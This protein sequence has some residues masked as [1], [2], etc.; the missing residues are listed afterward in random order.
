MNG[1]KRSI[2][3]VTLLIFCFIYLVVRGIQAAYE[4]TISGRARN[5]LADWS[6]KVNN[7][8][9]TSASTEGIP[10][11]YTVTDLTNVRSGKVAPGTS[12]SYPIQ[13]D[14]S[15]SEV[16]IKFTMD[17]I[18]STVDPDKAMTLMSITN[19]ATSIPLTRT[20]PK[21]YTGVIT[22]A[23]LDNNTDYSY[24]MAFEFIDEEI[25]LTESLLETDSEDLFV[26]DFSAIQYMGETIT[27]YTGG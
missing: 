5:D 4:S 18:D 8:E 12:L 2:L 19:G 17:I 11:T 9:I 1:R 14:A 13:I 6:V 21:S 3:V 25:E 24:T 23:M 7:Q 26:I 15:G 20:G 27:P 10:L 16:A 22:K